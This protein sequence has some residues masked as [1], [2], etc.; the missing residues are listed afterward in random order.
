ML[1]PTSLFI[2]VESKT[3]G[4][5][6]LLSVWGILI[7]SLLRFARIYPETIHLLIQDTAVLRDAAQI[8]NLTDPTPP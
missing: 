4:M 7:L 2:R 5:K 6:E 8:P 3:T 1:D